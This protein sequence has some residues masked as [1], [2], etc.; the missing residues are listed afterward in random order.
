AIEQHNERVD[1][2]RDSRLRLAELG[3]AAVGSGT[4]DAGTQELIAEI[5]PTDGAWQDYVNRQGEWL[6]RPVVRSIM[7][8]LSTIPAKDIP[9]RWR[10]ELSIGK[11][12]ETKCCEAASRAVTKRWTRPTPAATPEELATLGRSAYEGV[13]ATVIT[14][15]QLAYA[16]NPKPEHRKELAAL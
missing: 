7:K 1:A 8:C 2:M 14:L 9:E 12:I 4:A 6:I 10:D 15:F 13:K 3:L 16:T 11:L 5:F